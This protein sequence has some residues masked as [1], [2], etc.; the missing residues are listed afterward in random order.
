MVIVITFILT[1][2]DNKNRRLLCFVIIVKFDALTH[3]S[4]RFFFKTNFVFFPSNCENWKKI[5]KYLM[6]RFCFVGPISK[7]AVSQLPWLKVIIELDNHYKECCCCCKGRIG[8]FVV[9]VI[10]KGTKTFALLFNCKTDSSDC[11]CC[12]L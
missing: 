6:R 8:F 4:C 7:N 11:C 10:L 5:Y 1:Q 3:V 9:V 12:G 2:S